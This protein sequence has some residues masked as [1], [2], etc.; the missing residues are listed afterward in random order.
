VTAYTKGDHF[1][2]D[3]WN[4]LDRFANTFSVRTDGS[5]ALPVHFLGLWD[6][7]K[8]LG[9]LRSDPKWPYTR[10][11]PNAR[12]VF[13]AVSIDERRRPYH[14][15][16][17]RPSNSVETRET[18]FA[19]VHSDVGG[20]FKDDPELSRI[21]LKWMTDRA[22]DHGLLLD[23][24]AYERMCA[25]TPGDANG[26]MHTN[27]WA[28]GALTFRR[29]PITGEYPLVHA[30]VKARMTLDPSYKLPLELSKIAWDDVDWLKP[31][32]AAPARPPS[33]VFQPEGFEGPA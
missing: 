2:E 24:G 19:G 3:D 29:R 22:L 28:W 8:A 31:H 4:K 9:I 30:S 23:P 11:L 13:H 10:Q 7:V 12:H 27:G 25:V 1:T 32:P 20:G 21:T 16:L 5:L 14:E 15:Y 17:V 6:S 26:R 33:R 18:W